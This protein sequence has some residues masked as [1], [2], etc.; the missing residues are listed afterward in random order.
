MYLPNFL[1]YTISGG[2]TRWPARARLLGTAST[3]RGSFGRAARQKADRVSISHA[4][5]T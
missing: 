3:D 2:A 1:Q 5:I 4:G